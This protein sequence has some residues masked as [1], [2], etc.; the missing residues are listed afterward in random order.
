MPSA[1]PLAST[2]S[3]AAAAPPRAHLLKQRGGASS[4]PATRP[5]KPQSQRS[6]S[7]STAGGSGGSGGASAGASRAPTLTMELNPARPDPHATPWPKGQEQLRG[8]VRN[9]G[10]EVV[11]GYSPR[12]PL[13]PV[14][15]PVSVRNFAT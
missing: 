13:D 8:F 15:E 10:F 3:T 6:G 9:P 11:D 1:R 2:I 5:P 7:G 14:Q 12:S 4:T